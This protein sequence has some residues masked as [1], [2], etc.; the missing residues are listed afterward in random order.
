[1]TETNGVPQPAATESR[2]GN[3]TELF[4]R[5]KIRS[6]SKG[7]ATDLSVA[8]ET[9]T[10]WYPLFAEIYAM[11]GEDL[12]RLRVIVNEER[13]TRKARLV[14]EKARAKAAAETSDPDLF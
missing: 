14:E 10:S 9:I 13:E 11:N 7:Q 8:L 2:L 5:E 1:M 4:W 12:E 3:V 6:L